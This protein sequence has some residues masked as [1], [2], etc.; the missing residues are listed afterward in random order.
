[1]SRTHTE[2]GVVEPFLGRETGPPLVKQRETER[3]L[4]TQ[5]LLRVSLEHSLQELQLL[6][7]E[8]VLAVLETETALPIELQNGLVLASPLLAAGARLMGRLLDQL[9][10]RPAR[11][12]GEK[13]SPQAEHV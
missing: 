10:K 4:R 9:E 3:L 8:F 13:H 5:P 12:Q 11:Q 1:M 2:L 6:L 7:A